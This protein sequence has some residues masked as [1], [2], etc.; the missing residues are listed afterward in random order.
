[1]PKK[2]ITMTDV[3]RY[4]GVS[5]STVSRVVNGSVNVSDPL[6]QLVATAIVALNYKPIRVGTTFT[7]SANIAVLIPNISSPFFHNLIQGIQSICFEKGHT[8]QIYSSGDDPEKEMIHADDL[9]ARADVKGV[10]F[11]GTWIWEHQEPVLRLEES[12]VPICLINRFAPTVQADLLEVE[13]EQGTYSATAHLIRLGH[14]RIG[15][16]TGIPNASTNMDEVPGFRRAMNDFQLETDDDLIMHTH[17]SAEGGY[18]AGLEL[19]DRD[20]RP[21]AILA[22]TDRLAIGVMRAAWELSI[23]IPDDLSIIGYDDEP[24]A[25]FTR[26]AL[27]TI[28]QPQYDMGTRAA[29][30]LFE[31]ISNPALPQRQ[32]IVQPQLIVRE[33]TAAP[34]A[35]ARALARTAEAQ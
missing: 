18:R 3:A 27:T 30:L 24:D 15:C 10:I 33:T 4:A 25:K 1:M 23:D 8:L 35:R 16:I 6:R 5:I 7:A 2:S 32:V 29:T 34:R 26:P 21:T 11:A 14:S 22:R 9:A 28:R 31:R 19:L 12:G 13:R 17:L 20:L